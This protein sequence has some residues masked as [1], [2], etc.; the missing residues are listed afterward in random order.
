LLKKT[1]EPDIPRY[2]QVGTMQVLSL[3]KDESYVMAAKD[4]TKD[5]EFKRVLGN[6]LKAKPKPHAKIAGKSKR[7]K[8]KSRA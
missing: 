8:A 4:P 3:V 7:K 6:L 2:S 1:L 5:P